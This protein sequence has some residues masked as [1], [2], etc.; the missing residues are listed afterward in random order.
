LII[1]IRF[2]LLQEITDGP[3]LNVRRSMFVSLTY[4]R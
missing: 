2:L 4:R 3:E 1:L